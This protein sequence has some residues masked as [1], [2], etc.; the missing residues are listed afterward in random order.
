MFISKSNSGFYAWSPSPA[1]STEK[2]D[3][4]LNCRKKMG[5]K[6]LLRKLGEDT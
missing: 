4:E 2:N 1:F 6:S 3:L 5:K